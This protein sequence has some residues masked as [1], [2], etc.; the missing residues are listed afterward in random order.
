MGPKTNLSYIV[1][2]YS[3]VIMGEMVSQITGVSIV[4]AAV[5][6]GADQRNCKAHHHWPFL[7]ESTVSG[8][9]PSQRASHTWGKSGTLII[10]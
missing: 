3:D 5:C 7:G 8:G 1:K 4:C 2:H 10:F 9:S 6:S